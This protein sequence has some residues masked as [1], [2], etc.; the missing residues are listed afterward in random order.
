M[1]AQIASRGAFK[2]AMGTGG[3]TG[4]CGARLL[5]PVMKV[6]ADDV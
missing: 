1:S 2:E 5:E 3:G 6:S 4:K